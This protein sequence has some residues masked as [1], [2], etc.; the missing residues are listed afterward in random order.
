MQVVAVPVR[1]PK[2]SRGGAESHG[3]RV[4][5]SEAPSTG[6]SGAL[7]PGV[8][9]HAHAAHLDEERCVVEIVNVNR[10][11][12]DLLSAECGPR[13]RSLGGLGELESDPLTV[14]LDDTVREAGPGR[15]HPS[16]YLVLVG[17]DVTIGMLPE[18]VA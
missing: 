13:N 7:Q 15:Q 16:S 9:E 11:H 14:D 8:E 2:M 10:R 12:A 17:V 4:V 5:V 18:L 1:D 3:L 6:K